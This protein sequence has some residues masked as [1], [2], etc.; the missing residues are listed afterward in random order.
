MQG[1]LLIWVPVTIH[2][3]NIFST[4]PCNLNM[5]RRSVKVRKKKNWSDRQIDRQVM[6]WCQLPGISFA[7]DSSRSAYTDPI[8]ITILIMITMVMIITILMRT[9]STKYE[10]NG[11][12]NSYDNFNNHDNDNNN[13]NN[14]KNYNKY[15]A[16][17]SIHLE[18]SCVYE[19][20]RSTNIANLHLS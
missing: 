8:M 20:S 9:I 18:R 4:T 10:S 13:N 19:K 1:R 12:D 7:V 2:E 15:I 11:S 5:D 3:L 16:K 17:S 6:V 14:N